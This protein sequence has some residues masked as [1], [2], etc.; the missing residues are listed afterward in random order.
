MHDHKTLKDW[1]VKRSG[2]CLVV[3]GKDLETGGEL[4]LTGIV[5]IKGGTGATTIAVDSE[6]TGHLLLA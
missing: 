3:K 2:P 4:K 5:Q 6:G 1:T